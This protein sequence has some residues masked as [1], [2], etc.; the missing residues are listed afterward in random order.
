MLV[1]MQACC[2][3]IYT[4]SWPASGDAHSTKAAN[5]LPGTAS[6]MHCCRRFCLSLCLSAACTVAALTSVCD[7]H[8]VHRSKAQGR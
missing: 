8:A 3:I 5:C 7:P 4:Y 2:G 1:L 6:H